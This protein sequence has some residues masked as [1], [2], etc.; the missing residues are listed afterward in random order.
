MVEV[1]AAGAV[2]P[3]GSNSFFARTVLPKFLGGEMYVLCLPCPTF[4][5]KRIC[6]KLYECNPTVL[7]DFTDG[8]KPGTALL[9]IQQQSKQFQAP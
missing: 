2:S 4:G 9:C 3:L 5:F 1:E 7:F 8:C 6:M